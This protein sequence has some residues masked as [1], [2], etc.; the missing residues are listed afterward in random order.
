MLEI[1]FTHSHGKCLT[2]VV[3]RLGARVR[4][5]V[6]EISFTHSDGKCLTLVGRVGSVQ[7]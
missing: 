6:L 2:L 3:S 7:G 4:W 1:S 5:A